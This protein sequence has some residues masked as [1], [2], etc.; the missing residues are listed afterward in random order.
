MWSKSIPLGEYIGQEIFRGVVTGLNSAFI[1]SEKEKETILSSDPKSEF[2]IKP[3]LAGKDIKRYAISH[4]PRFL[5]Y[6]YHGAEVPPNSGIIQHLTPHKEELDLRATEQKWF[7]LQQ[8]QYAFFDY[9]NKPKIVYPEICSRPNFAFD[10]KGY[11]MNNKCFGIPKA[12]LYFLGLLNSQLMTFFFEIF[13]PRLR[14]GF[15]MP[16]SSML[17]KLPI[18]TINFSDPTDKARHDRMVALVTQMLDLNKKMQDARLEQEKT[19]LS[20]QIA[21]TDASI[22]KLVYELYEL[23][24]E[25]IAVVEGAGK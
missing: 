12:D 7:E 8:P 20:R 18:R 5:I 1:I 14:G 11:F 9:F 16:G 23:T 4:Q 25:E 19:Q 10:D 13:I 6:T 2:F 15:F 17:V 21:A 3:M 24:A 22:D